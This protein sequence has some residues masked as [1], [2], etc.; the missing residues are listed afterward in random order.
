MMFAMK[1]RGAISV[2]LA[3]LAVAGVLGGGVLAYCGHVFSDSGQFS[4]RATATLRSG[5]V[6]GV[7]ARGVS[8]A[9]VSAEPDLVGV[10]PLVAGAAQAIVAST[11]FQSIVEGAVYD[12]HRTVFARGADTFTLR[13]ADVGVLAD[14]ALRAFA[15][16]VAKRLPGSTSVAL[17]KVSGGEVGRLTEVVRALSTARVAGGWLLLGG[18]LG[19]VVSIVIAV[20]RLAAVRRCGLVVLCAGLLVVALYTVA[21]PL[22]LARFAP[23]DPRTAAGA[24]WDAF[25]ADLRYWAL[26]AAGVGALV[27]ACASVL[28]RADAQ[29]AEDVLR[30]LAQRGRESPWIRLS[31]GLV[32]VVCGAVLVVSPAILLRALSVAVGGAL[33]YAGAVIVLRLVLALDW[34]VLRERAP[35]RGRLNRLVPVV[36][37]ASLLAVAGFALASATHAE[38]RLAHPIVDCNGYAQLCDRPLNAVVFPATHNSM[39]SSTES[40]WLFASQDGGI[41]EQLSAGIRGLLIDTH[42][43]VPTPRGVATELTAHTRKLATVVDAVGPEFI[44]A[45]DRLRKAIGHQPSGKRQVFLCHAFCEVGATSARV[46]L[47]Q[48]RDFLVAHPDQVLLISVEDDV[49]PADTAAVFAGSGLLDLVYE[50][51]VGS[52]WPTLRELIEQDRRV[53]VFGENDTGDLGWYRPQFDVLEETP[54]HFTRPAQLADASSCRPNRGGTGKSLFLLNNWVDTSPS[55][56]PSSATVVN[57]YPTLLARARRCEAERHHLPNLL[58]IDF[59]KLGDVLRVAATLNGLKG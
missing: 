28:G 17:T 5:A 2:L 26:L 19:F 59:F 13:L 46:A 35:S 29:S 37:V 52:S 33:V 50:A 11:P 24:V 9:L 7:I 42:Y 40:G 56:R 14:A 1:H 43:G 45:V 57:A 39:A 41:P 20:D 4:T 16:S 30:A 32:L 8:S 10:Q 27:A 15:P 12:V 23:G 58:A 3:W 49:S 22:V 34:P 54:F 36:G 21:R 48:I 6:R 47:G 38:P 44:T 51:P 25:L 55:P 18:V 53:V 31:S